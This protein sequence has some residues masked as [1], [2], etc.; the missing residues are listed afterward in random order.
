MLEAAVVVAAVIIDQL[1]KLWVSGNLTPQAT[2]VIPGIIN[3]R[4]V[5]NRGMAFGLF[6]NGTLVLSVITGI[7]IL[8][9]FFVI[10]K[11]KKKTTRFFRVSLAAI[12]G[13]AIG[14]FIDRVVLGFVV[15][16]I[17]FDFVNFAVFNFA[18]ICV[19]VGAVLLF[20]YLLFI[21]EGKEMMKGFDDNGRGKNSGNE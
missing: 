8:L 2:E 7:A 18:D 4:Y 11:Y 3:F 14:N 10:Y 6:Q 17:E 16:F 9:M 13:G 12:A 21:K 5:E 15:D 19:T 20:V 1:T